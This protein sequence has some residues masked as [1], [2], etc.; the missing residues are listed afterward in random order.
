MDYARREL[1]NPGV[2][3]MLLA[4]G[5]ARMRNDRRRMDAGEHL[6]RT[7]AEQGLLPAPWRSGMARLWWRFHRAGAPP[8]ASDLELLELCRQPLASW[9]VRLCLSAADQ[10][11]SLLDG[12]DLSP[13]AE[14]AAQLTVRDVE[15]ELVEHQI[16]RELLLTA[17]MNASD[18]VQ[19]QANYVDLRRLLID[20]PVLAD[21]DVQRLVQRFPAAASS[22]QPFVRRFVDAAYVARPAQGSV[23]VQV[24]GGCG[25]PLGGPA[26][27]CGTA[28]CM[29][30]A[31]TQ[32]VAALGFYLVQ[33]RAARRFFHDP[34]LVEAR[35]HDRVIARAPQGSVR[36]E[37]W[38]GLD[39]Y[40]LRVRFLDVARPGSDTPLAVWGADAKDQVSPWLLAVGFGWKPEPPCDRRF[41]VLPMHR[42]RQPGYIEDLSVELEGRVAGVTV[43]DEDRFVAKV[44]DRARQAVEA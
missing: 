24:C 23:A 32:T 3:V 26:D 2:T 21:R 16:F 10:G 38:P 20:H 11:M 30:A 39:A 18:E 29:G 1:R 43:M 40:D 34:G 25:N 8:P 4:A 44:V 35:V 28:G 31:T 42:A 41:L 27:A 14:Q 7:S 33:H 12:D 15:A 22:G 9:P 13:L 5:L 36:V 19:V 17:E 6:R 37:A